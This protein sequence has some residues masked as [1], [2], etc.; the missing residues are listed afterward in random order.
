IDALAGKIEIVGV[1]PSRR[2]E[3]GTSHIA[4]RL[5]DQPGPFPGQGAEK[6]LNHSPAHPRRH[7]LIAREDAVARVALVPAEDLVA[8]VTG[9]KPSHAAALGKSRAQ[10]GPD[11]GVVAEGL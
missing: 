6:G 1:E 7:P 3:A 9:E 5:P 11:R 2:W 8:A 10:I 4:L